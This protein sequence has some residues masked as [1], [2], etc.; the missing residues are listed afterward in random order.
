MADTIKMI[1]VEPDT[2]KLIVD[3]TN[4]INTKK[5]YPSRIYSDAMV[6]IAFSEYVKNHPEL[7]VKA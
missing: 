2:H 4:K 6:K 1:R 3:V 7:G 5:Y